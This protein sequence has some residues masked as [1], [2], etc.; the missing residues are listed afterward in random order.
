MEALDTTIVTVYIV[1]NSL[2][3]LQ[4]IASYRWP[5][6][7]RIGFFI[8]FLGAAIINT[9]TGLETPWL[10]QDFADYAIPLYR[11]F[12]MGPFETMITPMVQSIAVGQL[13]IAASMFME[14]NWFRAGCL[15]GIIFCLAITPLGFAAAFPAT[16]LMAT[17]FYQLYR[18][19]NNRL[20]KKETDSKTLALPF[21]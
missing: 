10:Y 4:W 7:A 12:I 9:R 18:Q 14:G 17:A 20:E 13:L 3:V 1:V 19:G 21:N 6:A 5:L 8:L 2:S 15:G 11:R 16:L